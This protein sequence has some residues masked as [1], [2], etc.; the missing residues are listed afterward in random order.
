MMPSHAAPFTPDAVLSDALLVQRIA[1]L[2][3]K[4]TLAELDGRHGMT[5][6]A[7][8]YSL[9][10]DRCTV[11]VRA[12]RWDAGHSRYAPRLKD[13]RFAQPN[14]SAS[15][16]LA[17]FICPWSGV[18]V[19]GRRPRSEGGWWDLPTVA[20]RGRQEEL[21]PRPIDQADRAPNIDPTPAVIRV[22]SRLPQIIGRLLDRG[23]DLVRVPAAHP[24]DQEGRQAGRDRRAEAR[25]CARPDLLAIPTGFLRC[26]REQG[27]PRT[28]QPHFDR[29]VGGHFRPGNNSH[30]P[31]G[32]GHIDRRATK[33][34]VGRHR[35]HVHPRSIETCRGGRSRRGD[36]NH[37]DRV[38]E[39]E[40]RTIV[41]E[42]GRVVSSR[43][44]QH[45][46]LSVRVARHRVHGRY[47][48]RERVLAELQGD[49]QVNHIRSV[50]R[51]VDDAIQVHA[52]AVLPE[53][54]VHL[55]AE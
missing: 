47:D 55:H 33:G 39:L 4:T 50:I 43:C 17:A 20:A 23:L 25:S 26:P 5:L 54:V 53:A 44:Y 30:R 2:S 38:A 32:P 49:A 48:A 7:I 10:L 15:G 21:R 6:Y 45:C 8:A 41:I 12:R 11:S 52:D 46:A 42:V 19:S 35:I 27:C 51:G 28:D 1:A 9:L 40:P 31:A 22:G 13:S 37:V 16:T 34:G 3:D 24:A 14:R 36:T 29:G 18:G